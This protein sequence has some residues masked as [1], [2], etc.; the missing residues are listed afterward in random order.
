M[1]KISKYNYKKNKKVIGNFGVVK[2]RKQEMHSI[3]Q[4]N[5]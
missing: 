5:K 1:S 3:L 4:A 2:Y